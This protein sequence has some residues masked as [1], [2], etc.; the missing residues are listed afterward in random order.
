M[1]TERRSASASPQCRLRI[2]TVLLGLSLACWCAP[3]LAI[4]RDV[5]TRIAN[6]DDAPVT[7]LEASVQLARTYST[8]SQVPFA[9]LGNED[10]RV[11]RSQTRHLNRLNQEVPTF[12]LEGELA[13]R[14]LTRRKVEAVQIT[15]VF[16]NAF[17]KRISVERHSLT[18]ELAPRQ[19]HRV[20]WSRGFPNEEVFEVVF[21]ITAVRFTDGTVWAPTEELI[22]LP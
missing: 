22:L 7:L 12:L 10:L 9:T 1:R 11:Q 3:A 5:Q 2:A 13:V 20:K 17:R 6:Y 19:L 4:Q 16:L 8:P 15:T 21:V 14:N 18:K